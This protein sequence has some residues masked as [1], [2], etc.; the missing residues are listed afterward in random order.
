MLEYRGVTVEEFNA[1]YDDVIACVEQ[2]CAD[3]PTETGAKGPQ[4]KRNSAR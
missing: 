4:A 2:L 3:L 1:F